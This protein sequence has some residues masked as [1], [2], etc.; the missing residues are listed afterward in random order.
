M[1]RFTRFAGSVVEAVLTP[2]AV[3]RYLVYFAHYELGKLYTAQGEFAKARCE[4]ELIQ[5]R[6]PLV[7]Q[8]SPIPLKSGKASYLLS[9]MCQMRANFAMSSLPRHAPP[10]PHRPPHG[11]PKAT[12]SRPPSEASR[13][14]P[15]SATATTVRATR[16]PRSA[17]AHATPCCACWKRTRSWSPR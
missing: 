13:A 11:P 7:P 12:S 4:F 2:H 5:S 10:P 9:H 8:D 15:S 1:S 3:D 17:V 16:T 6:K 14:A